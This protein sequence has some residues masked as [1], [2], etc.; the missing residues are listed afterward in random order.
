[1][2]QVLK[3]LDQGSDVI[4]DAPPGTSCPAMAAVSQADAILL[5]SEP[6]P[7]GL[8]D[9]KL[10]REA[11]ASLDKPMGLVINRAGLGDRGLY[12]YCQETDLPILQEIPFDFHLAEAYS[13]GRVLAEVSPDMKRLFENLAEGVRN[14][15]RPVLPE[16]AHA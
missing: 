3:H 8:Y 6:T 16:A 5:V 10:A 7:F 4:I 12:E 14:L 9:L 15:N 11:F 13:Q 1:M 2:N